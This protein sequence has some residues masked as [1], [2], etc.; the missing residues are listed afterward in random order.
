MGG[1]APGRVENGD[2]RSNSPFVSGGWDKEVSAWVAE[3]E[4]RPVEEYGPC[5]AG[6]VWLDGEM[7]AGIV[8]SNYQRFKCGGAT[9]ELTM[10][11]TSPRWA[12][13]K[14]LRDIFSYP[15]RQMRVTRLQV[16]CR[17]SNRKSCRLVE[18]LGFKFEGT[19]RIAFEGVEDVNLYSMLPYECR[20]IS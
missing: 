3:R 14:T 15:F 4:G 7:I 10:A 11:S 16:L 6:A 18:R 20:W 8:Y 5:S 19:A 2:S 17:V 1:S 9:M 12:T 13:R